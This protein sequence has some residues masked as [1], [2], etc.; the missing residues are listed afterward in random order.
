MEEEKR[1]WKDVLSD[2]VLKI[3]LTFLGVIVLGLPVAIGFLLLSDTRY[4]FPIRYG[5]PLTLPILVLWKIWLPKRKAF[6]RYWLIGAGILILALIIN[7][8]YI[9]HDRQITINTTP[10]IRLHEYMPFD[11]ES[12]I[13]T[14]DQSAS[15]KL[16]AD[17]PVVDGAAAVFP[18]YSAFV[19][20]T[21]PN[22][23][24]LYDGT[25]EYNNTV[26]GYELLAKRETDIFFGA[27]P[28]EE[29]IAFADPSVP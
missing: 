21:Y 18:L 10:N 16:R 20:A 25:L 6:F 13:A 12:K 7:T 27:Y 2:L 9:E 1:T 29:Q 4:L 24:K 22:W 3:I 8:V 11:P 26:G 15:L 28:S 14:L 5:I 17:L 23:V 19:N